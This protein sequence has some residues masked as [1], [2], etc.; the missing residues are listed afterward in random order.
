MSARKKRRL[1]SRHRQAAARKEVVALLDSWQKSL[2]WSD[3]TKAQTVRKI[4]ASMR[5]A[6]RGEL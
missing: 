5:Q 4:M 1:P 2:G 3:R 6:W